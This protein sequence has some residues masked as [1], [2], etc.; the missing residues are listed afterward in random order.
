[1]RVIAGLAKGRRLASV[2][3][4]TTRPVLDRVKTALF[5]VLRPLLP[6][7]RFLDL[8]AGS[9]AIGIE[10]LSQGAASCVFL[11]IEKLAVRTISENLNHTQLAARAEVRHTDAF[12]FLRR[13]NDS[14][15]FIYV[16]PPQYKALWI[17][18]MQTIAERPELLK[19]G[20]RVI[21]QIDPVE[22]EG[23]ELAHF[24]EV[25]QRRYGSTLLVH[26]MKR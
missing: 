12:G 24:L 13:A 17:N 11:D 6:G 7:T 9:G 18:A 21:V 10:A 19:D 22:Y 3:G 2:P 14:F 8:F 4:D 23:L 20:G 1:M 25:E 26:Y 15:D 16:A 5:D